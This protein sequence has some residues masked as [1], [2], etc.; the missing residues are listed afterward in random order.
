[1]SWVVSLS[2]SPTTV[3]A[4]IVFQSRNWLVCLEPGSLAQSLLATSSPINLQNDTS[5]L[6]QNQQ[7]RVCR[8]VCMQPVDHP[9]AFR[10]RLLLY[11]RL[12]SNLDQ[13]KYT[14]PLLPQFPCQPA[15]K[16][17]EICS[18]LVSKTVNFRVQIRRRRMEA[19]LNLL[20]L[21]KGFVLS[22]FPKTSSRFPLSFPHV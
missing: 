20:R 22:F 2:R 6:F 17:E 3:T 14:L 8:Y 12:M 5:Y 10:L 4:A 21:F 15:V 16:Y 18:Y 9:P 1:M 7:R 19:E 11:S 13:R